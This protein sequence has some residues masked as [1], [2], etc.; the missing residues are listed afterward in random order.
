MK[1]SFQKK[2]KDPA[3]VQ[4]LRVPYAPA[5]RKA[6]QWRWYVILL[7]VSSPL[8]FFLFKMV[9]S[10]DLMLLVNLELLTPLPEIQWVDGLP[11]SVR[12][13]YRNTD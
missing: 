3:M 2:D 8:L 7:I 11:V 4:G 12:F 9:K 6:A 13:H 5:R 10:L 1:I